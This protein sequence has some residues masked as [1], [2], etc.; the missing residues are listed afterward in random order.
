[1]LKLENV[2]EE[3]MPE[4]VRIATELQEKDRKLEAEEQTRQATVA[5]AEEVGLPEKY[6]HQAAAELHAR[7][8]VEIEQRRK[9]RAGLIATGAAVLG[10]GAIGYFITSPQT[11]PAP[12][13]EVS[14]AAPAA[15]Q[16]AINAAQWKTNA[17]AGTQATTAFENGA[18]TV[19]VQKFTPDAQGRY[20]VNLNSTSG[21]QNLSGYSSASFQVSGTLP[22]VRLYLENGQERWRSPV[23]NV[24]SGGQ[25]VRVD[26]SQFERQLKQRDGVSWRRVRF[27]P[28]ASV[29][30]FSFKLGSFVNEANAKGSVTIRDLKFE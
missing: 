8:V 12:S 4:I 21:R 28:P 22:S 13:A 17:N 1:V 19:T 3:K 27:Q 11:P 14:A 29:E 10:L 6:L 20:F 9:R 2:P 30:N 23:L 7:R 5:A 18:A 24:S 15:L 16:T 25:T 26:F